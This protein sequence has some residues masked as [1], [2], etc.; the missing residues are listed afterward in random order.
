LRSRMQKLGIQREARRR[1]T[2]R[3]DLH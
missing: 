3:T 2:R 1:E